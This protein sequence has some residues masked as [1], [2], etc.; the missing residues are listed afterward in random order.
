MM[1]LLIFV[2]LLL[3]PAAAFADKKAETSYDRVLK[4]RT[5][6]CAYGLWEPVVMKD[7]NTE[8]M[9]GIFVDLMEQ[10]ALALNMNVEWVL[11][12][13]WGQIPTTLQSRK[14][15]AHCAGMWSSPSRGTRIAFSDPIFYTPVVTVVRVDDTRFD[16]SLDP[17]NDPSI[18]I[19][20][21]DDDITEEISTRDFPKATRVSKPQLAGDE[22]LLLMVMSGKADVSFNEQNYIQGFMKR[23]PG[24]L[25]IIHKNDPI[26]LF[27]NTIGVE[28]HEQELL[29]MFNTTLKNLVHSGA[30]RRIFNRYKDDYDID[31]YRH[32][33]KPYEVSE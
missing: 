23:N 5:I 26:R 33:I 25:K 30:V 14:V 29:T 28:I 20:V 12:V 9:S 6:K 17:I 24:K 2:T 13:D 31:H 3:L 21:G 22:Q 8:E 4:T 32:P 19:A 1:R 7:P 27:G 18:R 16:E 11:E 15:D 10:I